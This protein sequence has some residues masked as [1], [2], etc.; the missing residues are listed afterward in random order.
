MKFYL[1]YYICIFFFSIIPDN[2][3]GKTPLGG[4]LENKAT[5]NISPMK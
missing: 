4:Y 2:R 5:V 3:S 1:L